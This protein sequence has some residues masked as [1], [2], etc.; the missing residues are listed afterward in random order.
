MLPLLRLLKTIA[1]VLP[2]CRLYQSF[3]I[4]R[5]NLCYIVQ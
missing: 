3:I 1:Y 5:T 2:T 4:H